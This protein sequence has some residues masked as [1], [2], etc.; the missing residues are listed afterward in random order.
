M[1]KNSTKPIHVPEKINRSLSEEYQCLSP[2]TQ[3][4]IKFLIGVSPTTKHIVEYKTSDIVAS[5][6]TRRNIEFWLGKT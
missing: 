6:E 4:N 5:P 2:S 3:R 1:D